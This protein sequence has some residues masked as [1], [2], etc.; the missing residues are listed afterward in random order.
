MKESYI[1]LWFLK[2][3]VIGG[4]R[5]IFSMFLL[6]I[7][8]QHIGLILLSLCIPGQIC[9]VTRI[10]F[11]H[12]FVNTAT[13]KT[14]L[15]SSIVMVFILSPKLYWLHTVLIKEVPTLDYIYF[16]FI[17]IAELHKASVLNH[18]VCDFRVLFLTVSD[19]AL[20]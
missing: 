10:Y 19:S 14:K 1:S 8:I 5:L 3:R 7:T 18:I 12:W 16:F 9:F 17:C 11:V 13:E 2:I 15:F 6:H 20:H 4:L